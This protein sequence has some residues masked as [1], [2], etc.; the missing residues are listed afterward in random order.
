MASWASAAWHF[1]HSG[2][3]VS[4]IQKLRSA[5]YQDYGKQR[6]RNPH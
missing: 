1:S 3:I 5:G 4:A 2:F 6:S